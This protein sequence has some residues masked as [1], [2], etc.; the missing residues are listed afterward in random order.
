MTDVVG[1]RVYFGTVPGTCPGGG[2]F[3][4]DIGSSAAPRTQTVNLTLKGL[5]VRELYYVAVTA[6]S[7]AGGESACSV[8]SSAR[9]RPAN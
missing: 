3:F 1:Y 2:S 7:A 6:V 9:A 8:E 4:V 5:R